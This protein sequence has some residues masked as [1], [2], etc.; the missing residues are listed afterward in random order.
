MLAL[1]LVLALSLPLNGLADDDRTSLTVAIVASKELELYPLKLRERDMVSMMNLV[2]EGLFYLDDDEYPQPDLCESYEWAGDGNRLDIKLRQNI[3]FHNGK[4]M[5]AADVCATLDMILELSGFDDNRDSEIDPAERGLYASCLTYIKSWA[6][7]ENDPYTLQIV[8]R[9]PSHEVLYAL[10]FP[11]LPAEE[12]D[13]PQPAGTGPYKIEEYDPGYRLWISSAS[14]WWQR[15]PQIVDIEA[16]IHEDD[17]AALSSFEYQNVDV[18]MTR[19]LSASR[20]SGSLNSYMLTY[21]TRQLEVLFMNW[22][23]KL[24]QDQDVRTAI[25]MA[26]DRDAII[27]SVYQNMAISAN[28]LV[29]SGTWLYEEDAAQPR[30]NPTVAKALLDGAGYK[31]VDKGDGKPPVR[32]K[33]GDPEQPISFRL[34]TYDEPGSTVRRNA[35]ASIKAM[36]EEVG[37]KVSVEVWSYDNVKAKLKSGDYWMVLGAY[38]LDV[39]PD[40]SFMLNSAV[41]GAAY[42]RYRDETMVGYLKDLRAAKTPD[43]YL[44]SYA[45]IQNRF[46]VDLPFIAMYWRTGA[47]LSRD[48]FTNARDIRELE[49]LRGVEEW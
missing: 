4:I 17:D 11:I 41:Y 2:Y 22:G 18:A 35:A 38:N 20:Y 10:T 26:I 19:S 1:T 33:N 43:A 13:L 37:I 5:T 12:V 14:T 34:L 29:M 24:F 36:L 6:Y 7:M 44:K 30:Y 15:P 45:D 32:C 28:S 48:S 9:Y 46:V 16:V 27:K 42:S 21:R 31:L 23:R 49:L 3:K 40:P 47:L 8:P 39:I 25:C